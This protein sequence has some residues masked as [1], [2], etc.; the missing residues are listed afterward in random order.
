MTPTQEKYLSE[1]YFDPRHPASF[2]S[3]NKIFQFLK[4]DGRH[5]I[6]LPDIKKWI[7][8]QE[9]Y[10][11]QRQV[12]HKFA[13]RKIVVPRI[14]YQ[15][16][17]DTANMAFYR[18][19]NEYFGYFLVVV[20][21]FSRFAYT[22]PLK[23]TTGKEMRKVLQSI[24]DKGKKPN[25]LRTDG[26]SEFHNKWVKNLL[27]NQGI[28]HVITRNEV[29]CAIAERLIKTLKTKLTRYMTKRQTHRW[30]DALRDV[31]ESY[32]RTFH[33]T[34]GRA[35][36]DVLPSDENQLWKRIYEKIP[37][38]RRKPSHKPEY[39]LN[40]GDTVRISRLK[41]AFQREYDERWTRELFLVTD[42]TTKE[43]KHIYKIKDY[44]NEAIEAIL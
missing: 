17:C 19:S 36:I 9:S 11:T 20:D 10:T 14:G 21:A 32:N 22:H 44:A 1:I 38:P 15:W 35:P 31:T 23:T 5:L 12:T 3:P 28:K 24:F 43:G 16:E 18:K 6:S 27:R 2:S 7:Q 8:S 29:K 33:R 40:T 26:G 30:V 25:I 13:R 42:R 39:K 4:K 41:W 34:L 37:A